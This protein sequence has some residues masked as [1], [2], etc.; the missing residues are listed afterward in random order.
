[1][2]EKVSGFKHE[3]ANFY[4][5]TD[6]LWKYRIVDLKLVPVV[7]I[8]WL[9]T[10][11]ERLKVEKYWDSHSEGRAFDVLLSAVKKEAGLK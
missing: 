10:E 7:S 2:S 9:E 6:G 5:D 3:D 4:K 8:E 11:M 1:M